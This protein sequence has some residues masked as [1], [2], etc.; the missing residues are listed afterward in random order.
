MDKIIYVDDNTKLQEEMSREED[1]LSFNH[2]PFKV[3]G[4]RAISLV[5]GEIPKGIEVMGTYSEIFSDPVLDAKYQSVYPY[6]DKIEYV[7]EEGNTQ[8]YYLPKKIGEFAS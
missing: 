4:N 3:D 7:D 8:G 6:K 5:R 2:T 1:P